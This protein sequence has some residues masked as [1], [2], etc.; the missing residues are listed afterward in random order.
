MLTSQGGDGLQSAV[1][2]SFHAENTKKA[3][4]TYAYICKI[5]RRLVK[6]VVCPLF[7]KSL[8]AFFKV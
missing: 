5:K 7:E 4:D 1:D 2:T 3:N 8:C 6:F